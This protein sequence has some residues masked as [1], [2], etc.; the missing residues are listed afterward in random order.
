[1]APNYE[2]KNSYSI[3]ATASDGTASTTQSIQINVQDVTE[4][5]V[6]VGTAYSYSINGRRSAEY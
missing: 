5:S 6:E 2:S 4:Y 3:D 1:M